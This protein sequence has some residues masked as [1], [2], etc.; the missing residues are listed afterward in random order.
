MTVQAQ[1]I[2]AEEIET[3]PTNEGGQLNKIVNPVLKM[4]VPFIPAGLTFTVTII[5]T[6]IDFSTNHNFSISL[7]DPEKEESDEHYLLYNTGDQILHKSNNLTDNFNFNINLKNIPFRRE[8]WFKII[9]KLNGQ[10]FDQEFEVVANENL[11]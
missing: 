7:I 8:G 4:R 3:F 1:I 11:S 9:L 5:T 6:G 10:E 2:V